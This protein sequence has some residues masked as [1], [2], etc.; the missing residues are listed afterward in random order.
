M[1]KFSVIVP[2]YNVEPFIRECVDSVL[3]Q[4]YNNIELILVDDGS[5]DNCP[6]ICDEYKK[7]DFRVKVIH[8]KNGGASAARNAGVKIATGEYIAYLDGDDFWDVDYLINVSK[9]IEKEK[10]DI[11]LGNSRFD[12]VDEKATKILL[13]DIKS[14]ASQ[15]Y[16]NVL[17]YFFYGLNAMPTATCHNV[18]STRFLKKNKITM[19][20]KLTWSED[21]DYF[22][23]SI[24]STKNI[25][26][27]DYTF[28]YYRKDNSNA[29]TKEKNVRNCIS[30]LSVNRKWFHII[31]RTNTID[32]KVKKIIL[33]RYANSL[34]VAI[35]SMYSLSDNDFDVVTK[36]I[37]EDKE[38]LKYIH[39]FIFKTIY[40]STLIIGARKT[41]RLLNYMK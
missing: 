3:Y 24:F 9:I 21:A 10:K 28:Y 2:V 20:E 11:Y 30:S 16:E 29:I 6:A 18:Y 14:V 8:K 26:F 13:Y 5:S 37:F 41:S 22:F 23:Q 39:G 7:R 33:S 15:S 36:Y 40:F 1:I 38:M 32:N 12:Y 34:M 35:K 17:K 31:K 27:F 4:S 19:D 25:G